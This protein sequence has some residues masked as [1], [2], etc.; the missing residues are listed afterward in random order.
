M[1]VK[2]QLKGFVLR[3]PIIQLLI[4]WQ[5]KLL[6]RLFLARLMKDFAASSTSLL[7]AGFLYLED[8]SLLSRYW[9][10]TDCSKAV[11]IMREM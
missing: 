11:D 9:P 8:F 1:Y 7:K 6:G 4:G 3:N 2:T 10:S 5:S